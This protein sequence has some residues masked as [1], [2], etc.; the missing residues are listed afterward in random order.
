MPRTGVRVGDLLAAEGVQQVAAALDLPGEVLGGVVGGD[1]AV[2]GR[3]PL[4]VVDA[5]EDAVEVGGALAEDIVEAVAEF[6]SLDLLGVFAADGGEGVGVNDASL[7]EVEGVVV[8]ELV[9]GEDVPWEEQALG[10]LRREPSLVTGVVDGEDGS[11]VAEDGVVVVDGAQVDGDHGRLPVVDV[12]DVGDAELLGGFEGGAAEESEALPVVEIVAG[13]GAVGKFAVEELR[14]VDEADL[15]SIVDSAVE[16]G[17]EAV[18]VLE[19]DGEAADEG[20]LLGHA[21]ANLCVVGQIEG[22]F[23]A[24]AGDLTGQCA[25]DVGESS[26]LD[27][28]NGFGGGEDYMHCDGTPVLSL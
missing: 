17:D 1:V 9:H 20:L 22:D 23:V 14:A 24:E 27:E 21:L 4:G 28:R 12:E 25:D 13:L 15:D 26:G 16:D 8:L 7:E 2:G 3:V 6:G 10:G 19:G 5:I 11:G 18:V